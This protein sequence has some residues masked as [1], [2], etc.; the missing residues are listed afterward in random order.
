MKNRIFRPVLVSERIGVFSH[1]IIRGTKQ[2]FGIVYFLDGSTEQ[3]HHKKIK[4]L[5]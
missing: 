5:I 3:V 1:F 4:F 2:T